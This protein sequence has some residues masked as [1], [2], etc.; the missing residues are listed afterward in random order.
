MLGIL[1][2]QPVAVGTFIRQALLAGGAFGLGLKAEQIAA[3]VLVT[4]SLIAL[5]T[6][7]AVT[8]NGNVTAKVAAAATQAAKIAATQAVSQI[9]EATVGMPGEVT[10]E[11]RAIVA[12]A[13]DEAAA[14]VVSQMKM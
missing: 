1:R 8:P 12:S 14:G 6:A 9:T 10:A 13:V 4:E 7:G 2:T 11:A 5:L 3:I